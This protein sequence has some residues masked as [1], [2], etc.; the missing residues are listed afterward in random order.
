MPR[1]KKPTPTDNPFGQKLN[2]YLDEIGRTGDYSFV[3]Q[4]FGMQRPSITGWVKH[5]HFAK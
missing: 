5:G 3:A 4:A 2:A 1:Q